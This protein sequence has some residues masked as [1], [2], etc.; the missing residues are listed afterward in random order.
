MRLATHRLPGVV[1]T[2]HQWEVPLDHANPDG[3]RITVFGRE[4]VGP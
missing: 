3:P 4:V 1:T 2:D